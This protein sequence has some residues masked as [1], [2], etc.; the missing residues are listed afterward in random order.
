MQDN[1]GSG[2]LNRD[3]IYIKFD[4]LVS[5]ISLTGSDAGTI[6][7]DKAPD[8]RCLFIC[9]YSVIDANI[10]LHCTCRDL[11]TTHSLKGVEQCHIKCYSEDSKFSPIAEVILANNEVRK[12]A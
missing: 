7:P 9:T 2:A 5:E 10:Y 6:V 8:K 3:S 4:P 12:I 11:D 1:P